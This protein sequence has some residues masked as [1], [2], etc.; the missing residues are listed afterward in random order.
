MSVRA[1]LAALAVAVLALGLGACARPPAPSP[2]IETLAERYAVARDHREALLRA[3]TA[4]AVLRVDGRATGKLPA[5]PAT[6]ALATPDRVRLRVS[7]LVGVALDALVT[8][9]SVWAWVPSQKLVFAAPGE[10]LGIAQ[11]AVLAGRVVGATWSPPRAAWTAAAHDST[12][13]HLGWREGADSLAL[14]VGDDGTV[15]SAWQGRDRFGVAVR[16]RA[17][18]RV[19]GEPLPSRLEMA[20]DT[21]WARLRID[22]LES[23][24]EDRAD[25]DWFEPR[26]AA[27]WSRLGWEELKAVMQRKAMP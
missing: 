12:G 3:W 4:D 6:L 13:W 19:K 9:D 5:L 27:G 14:V 11:P 21:G 2:A 10:S 20:D 26:R 23:R 17:W 8:R 15:A 7:A 24:A 16:Y 25:D 22:L 18:E 1:R